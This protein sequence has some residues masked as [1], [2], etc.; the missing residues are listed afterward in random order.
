MHAF[1]QAS[2]LLVTKAGGLTV[3]EALAVG[4]PTVFCGSIP[5]QEQSN[6]DYVV[7]HGA[8]VQVASAPEAVSMVRRLLAEPDRLTALRQAAQ[9]LARPDAAQQIVTRLAD[10]WLAASESER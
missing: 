7:G 8:G 10:P 1:M 2:D 4:L 9:R 6:A 5:G 3:M